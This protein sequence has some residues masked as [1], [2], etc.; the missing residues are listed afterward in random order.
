[1]AAHVIDRPLMTSDRTTHQAG[2][3]GQGTHAGEGAVG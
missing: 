1:M 2:S 3:A